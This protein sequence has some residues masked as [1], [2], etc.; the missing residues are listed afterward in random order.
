MKKTFLAAA[1]FALLATS[2]S[3]HV[4]EDFRCGPYKVTWLIG[5]YVSVR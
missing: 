4:L 1:A 5:K 3:A 2:A